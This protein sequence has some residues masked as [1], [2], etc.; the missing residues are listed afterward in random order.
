MV[1]EEE[2]EVGV[3]TRWSFRAERAQFVGAEVESFAMEF[4]CSVFEPPRALRGADFFKMKH[5]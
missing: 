4:A 5:G 2:T 3:G 1:G